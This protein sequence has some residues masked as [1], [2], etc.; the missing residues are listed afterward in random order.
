MQNNPINHFQK[1]GFQ[2]N[3]ENGCVYGLSGP[4]RTVCNSP[5]R[6]RM[7]ALPCLVWTGVT[8]LLLCCLA[9]NALL[10]FWLGRPAT[11][12][13]RSLCRAEARRLEASECLQQ[14][15]QELCIYC[16]K[17]SNKGTSWKTGTW[18][19]PAVKVPFHSIERLKMNIIDL[20]HPTHQPVNFS[21]TDYLVALCLEMTWSE[22]FK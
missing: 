4:V 21:S 16:S 8:L 2:P 15:K 13:G 11:L 6:A 22:R 7:T 17:A 20:G 1:E 18:A 19:T 9:C 14:K 12:L 10:L 5:I 3:N